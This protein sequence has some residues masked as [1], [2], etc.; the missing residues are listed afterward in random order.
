MTKQEAPGSY[1]DFIERFPELGR[2]WELAREGE[3]KTRFDAK[4]KRL[5]KL[6]VAAGALR[7]GGV[8]SAVRKALDAGASPDEV[9]DVVAL[10]ASTLGFPSTVAVYTWVREAL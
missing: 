1:R 6:A 8:H 3:A 10:A 9:L 5:L 2:A 4:T 7:E